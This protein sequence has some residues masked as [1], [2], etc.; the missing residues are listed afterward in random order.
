MQIH[1]L[2]YGERARKDLKREYPEVKFED[3]S[4]FLHEERFQISLE[5]ELEDYYFWLIH[6]GWATVSLWFQLDLRRGKP[7]RTK[8]IE[9]ALTRVKAQKET[10]EED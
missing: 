5:A 9:R 7:E 2:I 8:I 1:D 3:A 6:S 4:D 10:N